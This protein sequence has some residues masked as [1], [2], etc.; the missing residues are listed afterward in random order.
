M[1]LRLTNRQL[2]IY[3]LVILLTGIL[4]GS[5]SL[6]Y[7]FGR[8]QAFYAYAGKLLLE[9]K[10]NYLHVIDLKPPG[11]HL[12]FAFT[13]LLFGESMFNA[14]VFDMLWQSITAFIVFLIS[15]RLTGKKFLSYISSFIYL[16]LYYRQDYWHTL[17][18]DGMLNLPV[19]VCVLLLISSYDKHSF[20]KILFAGILFSCALLFKYT[21]ISFLPLVIICFLFSDKEPK[22]IKFKNIATFLIGVIVL[23]GI[24]ALWYQLSGALKDLID[25]QF[26]QASQYTK[27]AYETEPGDYIANQIL[28]LFTFSVYAPLV[29]FSFIG[30]IILRMK[31]KLNFPNAIVLVWILSSLFSLIIQWKFYYY[32]FLVII[33]ALSVGGMIFAFVAIDYFKERRRKTAAIVFAVILVGFTL[34][35]A[36]PYLESYGTLFIYLSG[37]QTLKEVYIKNG[38]TSDSVFMVSKTLNAV[39]YVNQNTNITDKVF[40]WGYDPLVYYLTGRECVSRFVYHIPLLWKAENAGFRKEFMVEMNKTNPKLIIIASNDPLY[41]ISGYNEDSKQLLERF[42]EFKNF[43][44]TKYSFKKRIDDYDFYELKNW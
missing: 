28:K 31:R 19:A 9:G 29:W 42:P 16:L 34:Y 11:S 12:Y 39:D 26:G 5:V 1:I 30:F 20:I 21:L 15:F 38:F 7:P 44:D 36:K 32:H 17:Q 24:T 43:I 4:I 37:K 22:S 3:G 25:I 35:A 23:C 18:A 13:Q 10:M 33:A 27:I 6:T 8:D 41:Y 14:R 40:V 2:F